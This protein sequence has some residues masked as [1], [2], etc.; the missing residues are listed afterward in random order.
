MERLLSVVHRR[1]FRLPGNKL[2]Q[3]VGTKNNYDRMDCGIMD[4]MMGY[5]DPFIPARNVTTTN[6]YMWQSGMVFNNM[7]AVSPQNY[8]AGSLVVCTIAGESTPHNE[9]MAQGWAE[10]DIYQKRGR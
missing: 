10:L 5:C 7:F 8:A 2:A 6:G 9:Y 1:P 3:V 4:A